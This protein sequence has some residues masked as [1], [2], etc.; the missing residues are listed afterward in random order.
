MISIAF[1]GTH[2]TGK[3]TMVEN[4]AEHHRSLGNTVHI[5]E[6]VARKCKFTLGT[7]HAQRNIWYMQQQA[8]R[9]AFASDAD[10]LIFDRTVM[11]NL[12]Y[13]KFILDESSGSLGKESFDF[14]YAVAKVQMGRYD[15]ICRLPLNLEYL[16]ADDPIRPKSMEY[17]RRIDGIFDTMVD[18]YVN[19]TTDEVFDLCK[20]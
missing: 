2:A 11:D 1:T 4:L 17:A 13:F 8:E 15:Y 10:V 14:F 18:D 19:I 6:E 5:T 7:V 3:T 12:C 16:K 20:N 9:E